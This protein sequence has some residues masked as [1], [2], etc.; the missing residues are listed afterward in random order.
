L[1][2]KLLLALQTMCGNCTD[3]TLLAHFLEGQ[4]LSRTNR[5]RVLGHNLGSLSRLRNC[6][7]AG[8]VQL[9]FSKIE[10]ECLLAAVE[11]GRRSVRGSFSS[12]AAIVDA[13]TAYTCL[14]SEL[15]CRERE[16]FVVVLLDIKNRPRQMLTVAE[17]SVDGCAVDLREVFAP[18]VRERASSI[19]VAHNHPSGDPT[20]SAQD[21]QLTDRLTQAGQLLGIQVLD[22]LI[23]SDNDK[24]EAPN[25]VSLAATAK[26]V[27]WQSEITG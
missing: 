13:N 16:R 5:A 17:G 11:L 1:A 9:G 3:L 23:V 18:A 19:L 14:K 7:Q 22:H 27:R 4:P 10:A 2:R 25:F 12:L 20:P 6:G 24:N 26:L 21:V 8:L 15:L